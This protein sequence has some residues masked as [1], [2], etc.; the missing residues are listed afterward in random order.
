MFLRR[1]SGGGGEEDYGYQEK[2]EY[3]S[4]WKQCTQEMR[5]FLV[6]A[7]KQTMHVQ[8]I[9]HSIRRVEQVKQNRQARWRRRRVQVEFSA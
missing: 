6:R 8:K 3:E 9:S 2:N 7:R 5:V 4:G 1:N